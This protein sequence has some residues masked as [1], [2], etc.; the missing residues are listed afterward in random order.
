MY[1]YMAEEKYT[2]IHIYVYINIYSIRLIPFVHQRQLGIENRKAVKKKKYCHGE[3]NYISF[4]HI[5]VFW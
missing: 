3:A 1:L 4:T 5:Q 2:Y